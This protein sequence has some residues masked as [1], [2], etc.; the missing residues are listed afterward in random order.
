MKVPCITQ[1]S[2]VDRVRAEQANLWTAKWQ[3]CAPHLLIVALRSTSLTVHSVAGGAFLYQ[4]AEIR[5]WR[6]GTKC[7]SL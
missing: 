7:D 5:L 3:A 6:R 4:A 2:R 1:L